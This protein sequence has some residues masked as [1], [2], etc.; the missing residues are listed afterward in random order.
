VTDSQVPA[1]G[2]RGIVLE[3]FSDLSTMAATV[4]A[5]GL[6][7]SSYRSPE[8]V[9]VAMQAGMELGLGPMTSLNNIHVIEGRPAMSGH[10]ML[11]LVQVHP[12][13]AGIDVQH[14]DESCTVTLSR[15]SNGEVSRVSSTFSLDDA[16]RAGLLGKKN[17][18]AWQ[19]D[20]LYVRALSRCIRHAF[21]DA[22][23]IPCSEE[24]LDAGKAPRDA[25]F[26]V[27]TPETLEELTAAATPVEE[28]TTTPDEAEDTPAN[29]F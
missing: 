18:K 12:Q 22:I 10:L 20:M 13:Y 16:R 9:L 19:P 17:W 27:R 6:A 2:N 8:Q 14:A 26:S 1:V 25:D 21:A 7:P 23:T 28:P 24:L 3:T 4:Y 29:F 5:S 11:G 15:V